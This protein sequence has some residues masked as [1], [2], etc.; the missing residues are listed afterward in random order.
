VYSLAYTDRFDGRTPNPEN[1]MRYNPHYDRRH[2]LNFTGS[3]KMGRNMDWEASIRW[4]LGTGFPFTKTQG[5]YEILTL[6]DGIFSDIITQNGN[7]G[8]LYNEE[9]NTGR[10]PDYHRLDAS[11]KKNFAVGENGKVE[12]IISVTNVYDRANIFYFDRITTERVDQLPI[13]PSMGVS[14]SF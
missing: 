2:N 12:A 9:I 10:L 3:Y 13:L 7:L 4:N 14:F 6:N 11:L 1:P 8:I 5:F